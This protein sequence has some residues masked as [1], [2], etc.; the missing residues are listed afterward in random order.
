MPSGTFYYSTVSSSGATAFPWAK[1]SGTFADAIKTSGGANANCEVTNFGAAQE[2]DVLLC[3]APKQISDDQ[4]LSSLMNSTATINSGSLLVRRRGND[5]SGSGADEGEIVIGQIRLFDLDYEDAGTPRNAA[6]MTLPSSYANAT[7]NFDA[8]DF[9]DHELI[10]AALLRSG[11]LGIAATIT[12]TDTG[13]TAFIDLITLT[14]DWTNGESAVPTDRR[15]IAGPR[16]R[17][18]DSGF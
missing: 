15:A 3:S 17:F 7:L 2:T 9:D 16:R 6:A 18:R 10:T 12:V 14:L 5:Q 8:T 13:F 1:S 4:A 11:F